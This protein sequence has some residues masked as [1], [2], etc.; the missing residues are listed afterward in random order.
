M[1]TDAC[2]IFWANIVASELLLVLKSGKNVCEKWS[3]AG[4]I[5]KVGEYSHRGKKVGKKE[6]R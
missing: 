6:E 2:A 4:R 5:A 3:Q 1:H